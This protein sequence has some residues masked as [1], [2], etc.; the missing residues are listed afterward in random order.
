MENSTKVPQKIKKRTTVRT[1]NSIPGYLSKE[2]EQTI[3]CS[4]VKD[5]WFQL[6]Y[7]GLLL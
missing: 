6:Y 7:T 1:S 5:Q 3:C 2:N 4:Q